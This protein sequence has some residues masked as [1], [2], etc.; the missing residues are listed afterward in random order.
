M[1]SFLN[2][3]SLEPTSSFFHQCDRH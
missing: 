1:S 3:S 2:L